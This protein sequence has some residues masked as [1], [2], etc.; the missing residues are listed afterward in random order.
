MAKI[1]CLE[2]LNLVLLLCFYV[3]MLYDLINMI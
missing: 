2:K 1:E 3:T